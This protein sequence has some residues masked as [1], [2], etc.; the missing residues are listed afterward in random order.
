M[1]L[2]TNAVEALGEQQGFITITTERVHL[3]GEPAP[4][5]WA[6]IA[7][8]DY[9]RLLVADT[10]CGMTAETCARIF[11]QFF[12][13]K[14]QG[15]GLGL[16]VVHGIVRSHRGAINVVS[17]PGKGTHFD[18]LFP[19]FTVEAEVPNARGHAPTNL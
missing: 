2:I 12:T 10:G 9:V 15:K 8:G 14:S 5:P 11:D 3:G 19:C 1:N 4:I 17:T 16:S 13:T 18:V 7:D 6:K